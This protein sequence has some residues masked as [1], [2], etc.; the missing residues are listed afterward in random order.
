MLEEV[1][2]VYQAKFSSLCL[3]LLATAAVPCLPVIMLPTMMAWT[4]PLKL[5]ASPQ[6]P[7]F[8]NGLVIVFHHSNRTVTETHPVPHCC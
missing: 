2:G 6:I 8:L 1:I 5:L 4:N 7:S 3:L